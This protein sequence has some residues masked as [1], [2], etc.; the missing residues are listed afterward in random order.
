MAAV[1]HFSEYIL[2]QL[3]A[4]KGVGAGRF[5]SGT[6]FTC[7]G[8][9]FGMVIAGTLYFAVDDAT[10]SKYEALGSKCFS[11]PTKKR[12]VQ[13]RRYYSVPADII[14]DEE[15]LVALA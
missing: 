4:L 11:Y 3:S 6:G 1:D 9:Q 10:R 15:A 7:N 8:T 13:V 2:E 14:E 5:F 12:T